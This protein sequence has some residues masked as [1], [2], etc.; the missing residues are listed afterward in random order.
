MSHS[1]DALFH[2]FIHY[3]TLCTLH[4]I[5]IIYC[6]STIHCISTILTISSIYCPYLHSG[7]V[8]IAYSLCKELLRKRLLQLDAVLEAHELSNLR[9]VFDDAFKHTQLAIY[10]PQRG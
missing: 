9:V 10:C 4:I 8:E 2:Q 7:C 6:I 1:N 3:S 5:H